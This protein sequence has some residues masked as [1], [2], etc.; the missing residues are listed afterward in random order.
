M[1]YPQSGYYFAGASFT[2]LVLGV[3]ATI[4]TGSLTDDAG[5]QIL[6]NDITFDADTGAVTFEAATGPTAGLQNISFTGIG[7]AN[8]SGFVIGFTGNWKGTR[9]AVGFPVEP[10]LSAEPSRRILPPNQV[11]GLW[12]AVVIPQFS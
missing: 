4:S 10:E 12:A 1:M 7:I 9:T 3:T 11:T 6:L 8:S 2:Q 5:T